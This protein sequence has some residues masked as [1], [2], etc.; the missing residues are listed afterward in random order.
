[1]ISACKFSTDSPSIADSLTILLD[2]DVHT[3]ISR[4]VIL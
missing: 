1:M 3:S 2:L 4:A